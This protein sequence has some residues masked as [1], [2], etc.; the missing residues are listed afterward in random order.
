MGSAEVQGELWGRHPQTWAK[1]QESQM[2]P[3]Y[4]ATLDA[5]EPLADRALLDAGCGAGLALRLAAD[6]GAVVSGL[7]ASAPLLEVA[8]ERTP[9]AA[10]RTGDIQALPYDERRLRRRHVVQRDPVR[11]RSGDGSGPAGQGLPAGRSGR[12]RS[13]G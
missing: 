8:R 4:D 13:V 11:R 10:L 1:Y 7:D 5:L 6:R 9:Q 2:R 12:D 3:L